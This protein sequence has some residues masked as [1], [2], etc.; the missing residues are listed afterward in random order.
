MKFE[1]SNIVFVI[2]L[3]FLTGY[4]TFLTTK[5]KLTDSRNNKIWNQL[6][7]RGRK[8]FFLLITI[9][10]TLILQEINSQNS[11]SNK[12]FIIKTERNF[13]DS[14]IAEGIKQGI[15]SSNTNLFK[16]LSKAFA[17]QNLK[18][19]T[20]Q[21]TIKILRDSI[22]TAVINNYENDDPVLLIDTN[23]ISLNDSLT[24]YFLIKISSHDA[25]SSNFEIKISSFIL[26]ADNSFTVKKSLDIF[27]RGL[28]IPQDYKWE[29]GFS[30]DSQKR[31]SKLYIYLFGKYSTVD[32]LKEIDIN[33]LYLYNNETKETTII[34]NKL[35][36]EIIEKLNKNYP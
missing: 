23:G 21:N 8:V 18:I 17:S 26:F 29:A 22:K 28:K 4:L 34:I 25:G 15:D 27:P 11:D 5:G 19:D 16:N 35:R 36:D 24:N 13:R 1:I 10:V 31:V 33:D 9:T 14:I 6:T 32:G 30:I 20:L 12:D 3:A 2:L 7:S